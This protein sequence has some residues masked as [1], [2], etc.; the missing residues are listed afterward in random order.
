[1]PPERKWM[2]GTAGGMVRFITCTVYLATSSF[3]AM[4]ASRPGR[5]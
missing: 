2:P 5:I 4:G 1:M 3:E